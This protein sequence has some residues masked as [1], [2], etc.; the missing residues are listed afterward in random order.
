MVKLSII[1]TP[2]GNLK[3]I[4]LRALEVLQVCDGVI[5]EDSRRTSI[6]LNT[7]QIKKPFIILNNFNENRIFHQIIKRLLAGENLCLVSDGGTPLISDPGYK[8][9]RSCLEQGIEVDSL[10]GPSSVI[11]ALTLSGLPPD[12]F[13]FLGYLPEKLGKRI[14]QL[15]ELNAISLT[16]SATYIIFVAPHKLIRTL[17][18]MLEVYG[19][20][21]VVLAK[22]LTK[23]HQSVI[24]QT[25]SSWLT[26]FH[27]A[28][29]GPKGEVV[30]LFN[31]SS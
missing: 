22:E 12:K 1:A 29:A 16:L 3:D 7:Y 31:L 14:K 5:C 10:P 28:V 30:L 6:L 9:I 19:D 26:D 17:E 8:L 4:T 2:I 11:T 18:N 15:Q 20:I 24:K 25:I 13:L 23:I 27:S 21:E